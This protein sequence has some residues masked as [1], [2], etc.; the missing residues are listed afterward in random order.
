M[1]TTLNPRALNRHKRGWAIVDW[2]A[3]DRH[4]RMA[5]VRDGTEQYPASRKDLRIPCCLPN[6][7]QE[8]LGL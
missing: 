2:I 5:I 7:I 8:R 3:S 4:T 1:T 6:R